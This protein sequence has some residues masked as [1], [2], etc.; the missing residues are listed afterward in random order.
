M[1]YKELVE[2]LCKVNSWL[3]EY[4]DDHGIRYYRIDSRK[5][6]LLLKVNMVI[7]DIPEEYKK[8]VEREAFKSFYDM[9]VNEKGGI[10]GLLELARDPWL[11]YKHF[12]HIQDAPYGVGKKSESDFKHMIAKIRMGEAEAIL[13]KRR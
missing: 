6:N 3:L 8:H 7:R 2:D 10:K 13:L 1:V 4:Y 5:D 9:I 11:F 12:I